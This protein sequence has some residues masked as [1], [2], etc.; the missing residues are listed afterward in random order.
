MKPVDTIKI[1]EILKL[2]KKYLNLVI[3]RPN[4]YHYIEHHDFPKS[5]GLGRPRLWRRELVM[6]WIKKQ[7]EKK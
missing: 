1:D 6:T 5:M 3:K 2:L 4:L 7:I